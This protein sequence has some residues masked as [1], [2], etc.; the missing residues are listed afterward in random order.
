MIN[1]INYNLRFNMRGGP[2][3][4]ADQR[5]FVPLT[6]CA[7]RFGHGIIPGLCPLGLLLL[8]RSGQALCEGV[9]QGENAFFY[10]LK[11]SAL[12]AWADSWNI[13]PPSIIHG[14][15]RLGFYGYPVNFTGDWGIGGA[16][17]ENHSSNAKVMRRLV[18]VR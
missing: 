14:F 16:G 15:S 3:I 12:K 11:G 5:G 17:C 4:G 7:E 2:Q 1:L 6:A 9:K 10:P 8:N 18:T 13:L